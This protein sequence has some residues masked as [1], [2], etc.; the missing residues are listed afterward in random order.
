[1]ASSTTERPGVNRFLVAILGVAVVALAARAL[2]A[3]DPGMRWWYAGLHAAYL[4]LF[5][6]AWWPRL[7]PRLVH[8]VFALQGAIVLG[9]LAIDADL[10]FVTALFVP[11][12]YQ[13]AVLITGRMR[14]VWV[15][16]FVALIGGS[17]AVARGPLEGLALGLTSMA[18]GVVLPASHVA[19]TEIT[20]ARRA[21]EATLAELQTTN[22]RLHEYAGQVAEL[23]ALEERNRMARE[24]H[25]SVSQ[26]MFSI[27][28]TT[29]SVRLLLDRDA[30]RTREQMA[31]LE[32]LTQ[33]ALAQMRTFIA[34]LRP[35]GAAPT[36]P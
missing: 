29:R 35:K 1:M 25:D 17:L 14:W 12:C 18:I 16:V 27:L 28:L 33:S 2:A 32:S 8:L 24:L 21:S 22:E 3:A 15:A 31:Q 13:A 36:D 11:L 9:L 4:A 6:V 20:A 10:D 30:D 34:D 19:A 7:P 5:L 23:A 26:T